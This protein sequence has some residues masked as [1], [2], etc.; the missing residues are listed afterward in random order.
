MTAPHDD[1]PD[2]IAPAILELLALFEGPLAEVRFP[3][4]DRTVLRNLIDQVREHTKKL[5]AFRTQL[6]ALQT[7]LADA[8]TRLVRT[9]EQGLAYARV[10]AAENQE[11]AERLADLSLG[12]EEPKRKRKLEVAAPGN[13][14]GEAVRL[15]PKRGR[16]PKAAAEEGAEE[17]KAAEEGSEEPTGS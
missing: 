1:T 13:G 2:L 4:I 11:L 5:D 12:N 15:P 9:A 16:K 10:F 8:Q 14:N 6:D 7:N 17:T 3:G